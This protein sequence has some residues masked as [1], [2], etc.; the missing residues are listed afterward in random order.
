[1]KSALYVFEGP[2]GV[3]KTTLSSHFNSYLNQHGFPS[4]LVALPGRKV[5]SVGEH[6]YRLYHNPQSFGVRHISITS[7]QLL[8]TAAHADVIE[9]EILPILSQGTNVVLD[10]FWWST[11][12]Y[13]IAGGLDSR[14]RGL[15]LDLELKIWREV[16][17]RCIFLVRRN[18]PPTSEHNPEKW[19]Q[20]V[21][22][23]DDIRSQQAAQVRIVDVDNNSNLEDAIS[24]VINSI[25]DDLARDNSQSKV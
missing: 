9:N 8:F 12:V 5:G 21:S 11:W 17:P 4:E 3:G 20:L 25:G 23:Y 24:S 1:M 10:R 7:E 2:N 13:S 18:R 15:L 6:I 22:L 19:S 14:V 16:R